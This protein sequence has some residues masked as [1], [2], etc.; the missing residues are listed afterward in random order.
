MIHAWAFILESSGEILNLQFPQGEAPDEGVSD[1]I[2][3]VVVGE[4]NLPEDG[5]REYH[6]FIQNFVYNN[7]TSAF[8]KVGHKPN[9]YASWNFTTSSW[10]WDASLVLR[11]IRQVRNIKLTRCDWTVVQDSPLS[12]EQHAAARTYRTE[13]RNITSTL[14]NPSNPEDVN[15][16]SPPSF[17]A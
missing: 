5:C 10:D 4:S 6:Y 13:L 7:S 2:R 1:G 9:D 16:P 12:A 3:T 14:D 17:L 8:V 15:W 11:D